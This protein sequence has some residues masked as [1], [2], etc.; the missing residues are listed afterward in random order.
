MWDSKRMHVPRKHIPLSAGAML[1]YVMSYFHNNSFQ[2]RRGWRMRWPP[3]PACLCQ[4]PLQSSGRLAQSI[5]RDKHLPGSPVTVPLSSQPSQTALCCWFI[6]AAGLS[7]N[8]T[9]NVMPRRAAADTL[10][11]HR[12]PYLLTLQMTFQPSWEI[13]RHNDLDAQ[14]LHIFHCERASVVAGTVLFFN[15]TGA[16]GITKMIFHY[17]TPS[18]ALK[19]TAMRLFRE[20]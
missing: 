9:G 1:Q 14:S 3:S 18:L 7:L 12:W 13:L 8:N 10:I 6:S 4:R 11:C 2:Q 5:Q 16:R 19:R 17:L 20:L 15:S